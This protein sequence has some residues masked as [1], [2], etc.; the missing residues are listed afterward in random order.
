MHLLLASC[1][2]TIA[3]HRLK[4]V[5]KRS[6]T[7]ISVFELGKVIHSGARLARW[8]DTGYF[9]EASRSV[10]TL[11]P[12][13]R[14]TIIFKFPSKNSEAKFSKKKSCQNRSRPTWKR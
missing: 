3:V 11:E 8:R 6:L 14:F 4:Q 13:I 2:I 10:E 1:S 7:F 12:E 5:V 9:K